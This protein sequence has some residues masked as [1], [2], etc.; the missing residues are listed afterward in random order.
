MKCMVHRRGVLGRTWRRTTFGDR[1]RIKKNRCTHNAAQWL[2]QMIFSCKTTDTKP[3]FEMRKVWKQSRNC[4]NSICFLHWRRCYFSF[5]FSFYFK[6]VNRLDVISYETKSKWLALLCFRIMIAIVIAVLNFFATPSE[7]ECKSED[8]L[9]SGVCMNVY[10][11]HQKGGTAKG[12][13]ALGF[14]SCCVC[15]CFSF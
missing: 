10:D 12:Q 2:H 4:V 8:G 15:K 13:C 9:R 14:G 1:L 7:D 6:I 11:C 5:F 3:V